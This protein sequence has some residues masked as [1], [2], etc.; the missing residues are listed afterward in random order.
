[1]AKCCGSTAVKTTPDG[2]FQYCDYPGNYDSQTS[3]V[4]DR[5]VNCLGNHGLKGMQCLAPRVETSLSAFDGALAT[6]LAAAQSVFKG[7]AAPAAPATITGTITAAGST[8]ATTTSASATAATTSVS[9]DAAMSDSGPSQGWTKY[10][11][12][13]GVM[14]LAFSGML[15]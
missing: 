11:M 2:C 3:F 1:M 9:S 8:M 12:A 5:S 6:A 13:M 15:I 4:L 10:A 7:S 14:A